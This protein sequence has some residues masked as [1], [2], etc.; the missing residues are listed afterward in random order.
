MAET[1]NRK[2]QLAAVRVEVRRSSTMPKR[3]TP[4]MRDA[5]SSTGSPSD[6]QAVAKNAMER[7]NRLILLAD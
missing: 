3:S 6:F 1:T 4:A 2:A 7:G 5:K